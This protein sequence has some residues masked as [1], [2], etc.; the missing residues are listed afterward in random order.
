MGSTLHARI[1]DDRAFC[2]VRAKI[3]GST[4]EN[5]SCKRCIA[6]LARLRAR[7]LRPKLTDI[8]RVPRTPGAG[9]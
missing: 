3:F 8:K 2:G 5:V 7:A 4:K 1:I 6:A 9:R